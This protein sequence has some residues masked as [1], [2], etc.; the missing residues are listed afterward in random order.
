MT[1][2]TTRSHN[3]ALSVGLTL[4]YAVVALFSLTLT[5]EGAGIAT[6]WLAGGVLALALQRWGERLPRVPEGDLLGLFKDAPQW[7]NAVGERLERTETRLRQWPVAGVL[8]L[9]LTLLLWTV[10]LTMS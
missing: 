6:V 9:V 8:L 5:R 7:A 1:A 10:A 4:A 2:R 3:L